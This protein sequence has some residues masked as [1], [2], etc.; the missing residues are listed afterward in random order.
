MF[1][2]GGAWTKMSDAQLNCPVLR[3]TFLTREN[4][5]H[6]NSVKLK[7]CYKLLKKKQHMLF[8]A[9]TAILAVKRS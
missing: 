5:L 6:V 7:L 4:V 3:K 1:A 9:I 2:V 8:H